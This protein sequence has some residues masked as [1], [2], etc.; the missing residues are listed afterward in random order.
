MDVFLVNIII[1]E[2][3]AVAKKIW[4]V[5]LVRVAH[6]CQNLKYAKHLLTVIKIRWKKRVQAALDARQ[7]F[8]TVKMV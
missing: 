2:N 1:I 7:K 4:L 8:L 3:Y 6:V 5:K